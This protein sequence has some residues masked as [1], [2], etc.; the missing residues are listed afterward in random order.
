MEQQLSRHTYRYLL[1]AVI[2]ILLIGTNFYH[3]VE[4]FSWLNAYYFSVVTLTT[5]GYGDLA[6]KT[7]GGKL[8]TTFFLFIGVGLITTFITYSIRRRAMV[9]AERRAAKKERV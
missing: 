5:V 7:A 9:R 6:P 8:F 2:F 4:H 3:F 1:A